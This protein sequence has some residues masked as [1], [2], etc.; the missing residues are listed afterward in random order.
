MGTF[1]EGRVVGEMGSCLGQEL[2]KKPSVY[3]VQVILN[4]SLLVTPLIDP[5]PF[6]PSTSFSIEGAW[7]GGKGGLLVAYLCEAEGNVKL[8]A[9]IGHLSLFPQP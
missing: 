7:K 5:L 2:V 6:C 1:I 4:P 3:G 9:A 8:V